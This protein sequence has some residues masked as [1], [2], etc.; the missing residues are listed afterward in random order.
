MDDKTGLIIMGSGYAYI[1]LTK[2]PEGIAL[3]YTIC[4]QAEKGAPGSEAILENNIASTVY[5]KVTVTKNARCSFSYSEDGIGYKPIT[6]PFNAKPGKWI[7]AK[8]GLFCT[9]KAKAN[10]NGYADID[11]FRIDKN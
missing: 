2:K 4:M 9:A 3:G 5:L 6:M 7:G 1:F 8:V 10:G 11:W